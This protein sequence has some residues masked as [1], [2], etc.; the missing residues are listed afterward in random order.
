MLSGTLTKLNDATSGTGW[1]VALFCLGALSAIGLFYVRDLPTA[2]EWVRVTKHVD[3]AERDLASI[4]AFMV[5]A[6]ATMQ[7][8][9]AKLDA[10][11]ATRPGVPR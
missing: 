8:V 5:S 6:T 9:E 10:M 2:R 4:K 11:P 7:R 1:K 3:T